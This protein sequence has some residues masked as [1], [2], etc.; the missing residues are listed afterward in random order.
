MT[1]EAAARQVFNLCLQSTILREF[2]EELDRRNVPQSMFIQVVNPA[3]R[4]K[5][6]ADV[7]SLMLG[8]NRLLTP[9]E[10]RE[11]EQTKN[12]AKQIRASREGLRNF[13]QVPS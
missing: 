2:A 1:D 13:G 8:E 11:D 7:V 12:L 10:L 4:R 9:S 5:L 3:W 6:I